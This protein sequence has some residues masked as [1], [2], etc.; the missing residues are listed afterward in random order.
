MDLIDITEEDFVVT[1]PHGREAD[2]SEDVDVV[3]RWQELS[4]VIAERPSPAA[5]AGALVELLQHHPVPEEEL[6]AL[7]WLAAELCRAR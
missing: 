1:C 7:R 4:A 6:E 2:V 5:V 3:E